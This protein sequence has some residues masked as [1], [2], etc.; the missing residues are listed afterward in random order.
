LR[1][2]AS[3]R[4][5][6][7]VRPEHVQFKDTAKLKAEVIGIEYLG[8]TQIVT[9]ISPHGDLKARLSSTQKVKLGEKVGLQLDPRTITLF[10]QGESGSMGRALVSAGNEKVLGHG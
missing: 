8:T 5:V 4:L 7:G 6:V 9:L 3:G 10:T 1:E 2:G